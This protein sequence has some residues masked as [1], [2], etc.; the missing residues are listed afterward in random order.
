VKIQDAM[1]ICAPMI[2]QMAAEAAIR[3][4]WEYAST[5]RGELVERREVLARGVA[6]TPSLHW[7]PAAGALFGLVRIDGC[8]DSSALATEILE[9]VHVITIPGAAFGRS[10]EGFLRMSFGAAS[11]SNLEEAARRLRGFFASR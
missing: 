6:D 2:G 3:E 1:I 11:V 7:T 10:G 5:F 9:R 4:S 8:Y